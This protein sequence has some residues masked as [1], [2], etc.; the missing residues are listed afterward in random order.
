M[1]TRIDGPGLAKL[2]TLDS[3]VTMLQRLHAIVEQM[4][5]AQR[6]QQNLAPFRQQVQ[7]AATPLASLLKP[8]FEAISEMV[9]AVILV[10][11]RGGTDATKVRALRETVA[12]VRVQLEAAATRVRKEHTVD[13]SG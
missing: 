7:R 3:A 1:T 9:T 8:Q 4:A 2:E 11:T 13:V 6:V 5:A 12:Q 10:T